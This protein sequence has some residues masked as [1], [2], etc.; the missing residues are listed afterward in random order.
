MDCDLKLMVNCG[1]CDKIF[2]CQSSSL[3]GEYICHKCYPIWF[4]GI[5]TERNMWEKWTGKTF[6][7]MYKEKEK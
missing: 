4:A 1:T 3:G 6:A 5:L 2:D 7:E